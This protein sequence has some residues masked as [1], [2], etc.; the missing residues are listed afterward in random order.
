MKTKVMIEEIREYCKNHGMQYDSSLDLLVAQLEEL[1]E[2]SKVE[3]MHKVL[4]KMKIEK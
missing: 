2:Q 3:Q 1:V 4:D